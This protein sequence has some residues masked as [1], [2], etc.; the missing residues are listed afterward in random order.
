MTKQSTGPKSCRG[1]AGSWHLQLIPPSQ[2]SWHS[3]PSAQKM[4]KGF[5][6]PGSAHTH[7]SHLVQAPS[8]PLHS[9][10]QNVLR[11][12]AGARSLIVPGCNY[13][14]HAKDKSRLLLHLSWAQVG[15]TEYLDGQKY[16]NVHTCDSGSDLQTASR[17]LSRKPPAITLR[18][19]VSLHLQKLDSGGEPLITKLHLL[20]S[21]VLAQQLSAPSI[22]SRPKGEVHFPTPKFSIVFLALDWGFLLRCRKAFSPTNPPLCHSKCCLTWVSALWFCAGRRWGFSILTD[23]CCT[24]E[25]PL[26]PTL[27]WQRALRCFTPQNPHVFQKKTTISSVSASIFKHLSTSCW[28]LNCKSQLGHFPTPGWF[29][30]SKALTKWCLCWCSCEKELSPTTLHRWDQQRDTHARSCPQILWHS[31][32]RV[33]GQPSLPKGTTAPKPGGVGSQAAL[34]MIKTWKRTGWRHNMSHTG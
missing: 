13:E 29:S 25:G 11:E 2:R 17:N 10:F 34:D 8:V 28:Q 19:N 9:L 12:A 31:T 15:K 20:D 32:L 21:K 22:T 16:Q 23:L 3:V 1:L 4:V 5:N 30:S 24:R 14:K 6:P 26:W 18:N 33:P 7:P 27:C